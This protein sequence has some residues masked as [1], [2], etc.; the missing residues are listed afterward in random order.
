MS[1]T[2]GVKN[3]R[4]AP[5][6]IDTQGIVAPV[7][8][9]PFTMVDNAGR[10]RILVEIG[11]HVTAHHHSAVAAIKL[12]DDARQDRSVAVNIIAVE[13]HGKLAASAVGQSTVPASAN[14]ESVRLGDD[15]ESRGRQQPQSTLRYVL[16]L[17]RRW[18]GNSDARRSKP[19]GGTPAIYCKDAPDHC[20]MI[21]SAGSTND[22]RFRVTGRRVVPR[23]NL[24]AM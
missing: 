19:T 12:V 21:S 6:P 4:G 22:H 5:K 13:L 23:R 2:T 24:C 17:C 1:R 14:T 11:Q 18:E 15:V 20:F 10:Y 9:G 16:Y 7:S 8:I 3:A